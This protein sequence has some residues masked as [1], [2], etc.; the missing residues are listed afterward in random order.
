MRLIIDISLASD[1]SIDLVGCA[2]V[3]AELCVIP[4]VLAS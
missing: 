2:N 4:Y 3:G 1:A